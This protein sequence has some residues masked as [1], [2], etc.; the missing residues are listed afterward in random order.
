METGEKATITV[1][2]SVHA[3]IEKVWAYWTEPQHITKWSFASD[4]WHA[5]NAENDLRAGG[6]FV[7]RMEAKDG[8]F[9][10]DFGGVYDEVKTNE[11][12]SYTLG[13]GRKV[14][15]QFISQENSV[16]IIE[17]FEAEGTHPIEQ[18]KA[19]WQAFMDNFKKYAEN[20]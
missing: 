11:W 18:Q 12:I 7:T 5:P 17:E 9:G 20:F 8:S 1:E 3:P 6:K 10:F 14:A 15:I 13:D 2:T 19:G 16:K 4:E